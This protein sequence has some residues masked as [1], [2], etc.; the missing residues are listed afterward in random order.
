MIETVKVALIS[1]WLDAWRGGA[2]TST[3]QFLHHL[4]DAGLEIHVFTRSRPS[5]TPGLHIHSISGAAMSRTRRSMT[6]AR[7]VERRLKENSFDVVHAIT[8]CRYADIYQPRGGT[9]AETIER[10]IALRNHGLS[11]SF[12][13]ASNRF[14]LK[15]RYSL[16]LEKSLFNNPDGP[17]VVAISDYVVRQ[18]KQ[19]YSLPDRRIRKIYNGTNCDPHNEQQRKMHYDK[20]RQQFGIKDHQL[21]VLLVAHNFKLK[22]VY[23][24]MQ[25]HAELIQR[26]VTNVRS[27]VIGKGDSPVWHRLVHRLNLQEHLTFTGPSDRIWEFYHAGD[28]L[29]HPSYYD[30]CSRVVLEAMTAGL[31]CI[32]SPWDGAS[33]MMVHGDNGFI[34]SDPGDIQMLANLIEQLQDRSV[35]RQIGDAARKIYDQISMSRHAT[36]MITLYKDIV[37]Q[38]TMAKAV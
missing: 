33:E 23:R 18:L 8:P 14:N 17:T 21:L 31:P 22:G 3:L 24:W 32:A 34:L 25:T 7:R 10:N 13:R 2:E 11:Q 20:I 15:Q 29:V 36:E 35:R 27:L 16:A 26:G 37:S 4:M 9:V 28:V 1:E 30:P 5:P 12:K 6:F 19:H 38:R